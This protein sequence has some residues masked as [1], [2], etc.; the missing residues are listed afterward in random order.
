MLNYWLI[1]AGVRIT[2]LVIM[3]IMSFSTVFVGTQGFAVGKGKGVP[4]QTTESLVSENLFHVDLLY[5]YVQPG[6][7]S[8][9]AVLNFT[10]ISNITLPPD[11]GI[12]EVYTIE[13]FSEGKLV[14]TT[15]EIGCIIGGIS[16]DGL[17]DLAMGGDFGA[18]ERVGLMTLSVEY[19]PV[20]NPALIEPI[21]VSLIR[22]GWITTDG[23]RNYINFSSHETAKHVELAKYQ[24]GFLYNTLLPQDQ[25]SQIDLFSPLK[26][27]DATSP[28]PSPDLTEKPT[29]SPQ[30]TPAFPTALIMAFI[31]SGSV[32]IVGL[33]YYK[34]HKRQS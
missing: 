20:L 28:T 23:S 34:K 18:Y 15:G 25:L 4:A 13:V 19:S 12:T 21:S 6:A 30:P 26:S 8:A 16:W 9:V 22:L 10:R 11:S 2:A 7:S 29:I 33:V 14:R 31:V 32:A 3:A 1:G 27:F 5:A 24:N 17:M